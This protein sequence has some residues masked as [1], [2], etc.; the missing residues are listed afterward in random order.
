MFKDL[1]VLLI[2]SSLKLYTLLETTKR[3]LS[4]QIYHF[5]KELED[6]NA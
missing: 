1:N 3:Y 6:T 4:Q 2:L 5:I